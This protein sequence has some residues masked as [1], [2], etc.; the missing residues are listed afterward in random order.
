[1]TE[2]VDAVSNLDEDILTMDNAI[3]LANS[4]PTA[5]EIEMIREF[6]GEVA[7]LDRPEQYILLVSKVQRYQERLDSIVTKHTFSM[8]QQ[9][10]HQR[11]ELMDSSILRLKEDELFKKMLGIVLAIGNYMNGNTIAGGAFGYRLT[12]LPLVSLSN[13][14]NITSNV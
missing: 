7:L 12:S 9:S 6:N 14:R 10:T 4:C 2:L 8:R 3:G 1:M 13:L 5:E 11:L